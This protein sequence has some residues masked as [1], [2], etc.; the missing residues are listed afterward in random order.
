MR[1]ITKVVPLILLFSLCV[2]GMS[3]G[4]DDNPLTPGS[5][6]G[7]W[8]LATF[9]DMEENFTVNAGV[10]TD[11]GNGVTVTVTGSLVLTETRYTFSLS[12]TDSVPGFPPDTETISSS[13]TYTISGSTLRNT[14][15]NTGETETS[16]ISRSGDQLT[17]EDD[18]V[19]MV[20]NK[21]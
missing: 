7:N 15:D 10:P 18:E 6:A 3:C 12:T 4:D 16:T 11:I 5:L 2:F 14:D 13:G 9:T 19:K 17:N 8:I 20:F 1:N 21:Q